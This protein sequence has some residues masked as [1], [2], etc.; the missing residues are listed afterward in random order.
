MIEKK[1]QERWE[2]SRA[3]EVDED[4]KK[5]V[6]KMYVLDMFP[7][8]SAQGLH[9]GHPEGYTAT[10]IYSRYLRANG[11]HVLHPMGWDAFGLPAENYA[12]K[13]GIHPKESTA[14]NIERFRQQIKSMGFSYDWSR[15]VN[16]SDPAYY[17]WTQWLFLLLYKNGL[18]YKKKA[19]VNWCESCQTVLANE[20]VI[21]GACERCHNPVTQKDLEQWFFRITK[22]AEALL[23]DLDNLDWPEKIK[24]MQRNWIGKSAGA[25]I[26]FSVRGLSPK[27][28]VPADEESLGEVE[29]FTTRP[30][31]LFGATYLAL[32]PEH[33]FLESWRPQIKNWEEVES[34]RTR[35]RKKTERERTALEKEKTGVVLRGIAAVNPAT[36]EEIPVWISDYVLT[37]YG[38]GAIMAVPAHDD[39]DFSFAKKFGLMIK[40][41]ISGFEAAFDADRAHTGEGKMINS[42]KFD[43]LSNEAAKARI[44]EAVG[45]EMVTQ[46]R[47]RDWLISRQRYWGAPIPIIYCEH[48][49]EQAVPEN[50]L[51]VLLP[52]D[53]DFRP[54]GESP[55]TRSKKFHQV[56][57]PKCGELCRRESDTM[58]TF[59]DSSWYFLRYC[60]PMDESA[61][62]AMGAVKYWCPVDMYVGGAEHAVLHLLYARFF[63]K[64]L[65]EFGLVEF[66]EP[67]LRLRNQGLILGP[68]GLKMSKSRGNVIN[69]DEVILEY[70]ADTMRLYEMFMGPFEDAKPWDTN[71]IVGVR[72][73]LEK[74]WGLGEKRIENRELGIEKNEQNREQERLLHKTIKKVTGDIQTFNFNTA[75][76]AMMVYVNELTKLGSP[77]PGLLRPFLV[78]LSPFAPHLASELWEQ[79]GFGDILEESWPKF[80]PDL[81][82]D[83]EV[84]LVI[85]VDSRVRDRVRVKADISQAEAEKLVLARPKVA[86]LIEGKR[87]EVFFIKG[88]LINIVLK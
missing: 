81:V 76:S 41:V 4:Q 71:G 46:Y 74:V 35:A 62:F 72:R 47:L 10:D 11:S 80:D 36:H 58:D 82:I 79:M 84:E 48:C 68:D 21:D 32:A 37:G 34:Y 49:G 22:Y 63:T 44:V 56:K 19:P 13:V 40:P 23:H 73:F 24:E 50:D 60:S 51:P 25:K 66:S 33:S 78:L 7:Y 88:R 16:T 59:V 8:P 14:K 38:V 65:H 15:E 28:T 70:G 75:V 55:L 57:C 30:D 53:V 83:E 67:F 69:P 39:R 31:T 87:K 9:V 77:P 18:A 1:W 20:Q 54:T 86:K 6:K 2:K 5:R 43:G 29:V 17:A 27:G 26:K 42:G 64:V 3:F 12:I 85:Q 45:G 61:A 52:S